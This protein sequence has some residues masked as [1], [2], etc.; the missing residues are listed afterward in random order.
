MRVVLVNRFFHPDISATSQLL[1]DLAFDLARDHQ[2]DV[3]TGR[4]SYGREA[5]FAA[6]ETISGVRIHRVWTTRF[7]RASLPGR[8]MDYLTFYVSAFIRLLLLVRPGDIV[9]ALTDPPVVSIPASAAA[10]LKGGRLVNWLQDMFPETA[11]AL[12]VRGVSG[13]V[14]AIVTAL[15]NRSLLRAATNVALSEGMAQ[16]ILGIGVPVARVRVIHNWADGERIRPLEPSL[17]SLRAH[18]NLQDRFVVGYSGNLGRAHELDV[19]L[20]A[21]TRLRASREVLFLFIGE[22]HQKAR[23]MA[24]A[25]DNALENVMFQ[26]YQPREMLPQSLTAPDCHLVSLK[27]SLE[28]MVFPSKLYSSLAAGRPVL[29]LGSRDS[30]ICR[31][32]RASPFGICVE[33]HDDDALARAILALQCDPAATRRMGKEGRR[34]FEARFDKRRALAAWRE[35]LTSA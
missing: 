9:V 26:P 24:A 7:G 20:R 1:S 6:N 34:L 10:R 31:M 2:V 28:G 32:M 27:G 3:I 35:V 22:G 18:W 16:R 30:E 8:A 4:Q 12:D 29:F 21:A 17:N 25:R 14:G 33:E 5:Q 23:L 15:R 13:V 19:I 11:T